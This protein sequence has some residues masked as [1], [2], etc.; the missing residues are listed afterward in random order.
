MT[1]EDFKIS[2]VVPMYYEEAVADECN[3]RLTSALEQ[4][5]YEILYVNDGS[6]DKT[7][8]ILKEIADKNNRVRIISF[9][10]NFGHQ[11]AVTAGVKHAIGDCVVI[12]DADLQDP[13]EL[14]P[15]MVKMWQEGN[16]VVYAKRK[17]ER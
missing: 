15:D 8:P 13:P 12:I 3:K 1:K 14:I 4:Y 17:E 16:D 7:L 2:V 9:S 6:T 10:R 11:A 5:D